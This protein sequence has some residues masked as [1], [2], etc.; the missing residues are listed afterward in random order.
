MSTST[1]ADSGARDHAT[2]TAAPCTAFPPEKFGSNSPAFA[3]DLSGEDLVIGRFA[4]PLADD[5]V[6]AH[7]HTHGLLPQQLLIRTT[8][9]SRTAVVRPR[10]GAGRPAVQRAAGAWLGA[11]PSTLGVGGK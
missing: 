10:G 5:V 8:Q 2:A 6:Q 1:P 3:L 9:A 4:L 11:A 7:G